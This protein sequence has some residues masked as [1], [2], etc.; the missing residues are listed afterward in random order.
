MIA[1]PPRLSPAAR[2]IQRIGA[3][4]A[5]RRLRRFRYRLGFIVNPAGRGRALAIG[6]NPSTASLGRRDPTVDACCR[7][8]AVRAGARELEMA[9]LFALRSTDKRALIAA[10]DPIGPKND[11]HLARACREADLIIAAW[12]AAFHPRIADRIAVVERIIA[13]HARAPVF[14]IAYNR[15]GTPAHP[16]YRPLD[17]PLLRFQPR[18]SPG[19]GRARRRWQAVRGPRLPPA[20]PDPGRR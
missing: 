2:T 19:N 13:Q 14:A 7:S 5:P 16:L 6:L 20:P 8:L 4:Q 15:D 12:G 9:N 10:P 18:S 1:R 17:Q 3:W 11:C